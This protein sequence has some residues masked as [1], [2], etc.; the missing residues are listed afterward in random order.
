MA[1]PFSLFSR[2]ATLLTIGLK[3]DN[4]IQVSELQ[5][6]MAYPW[7]SMVAFETSALLHT[8]PDLPEQVRVFSRYYPTFLSGLYLHRE[9]A[10]LLKVCV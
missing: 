3:Y 5:A 8:L 6:H 7:R 1:E 10:Q 2:T 9:F 4:R